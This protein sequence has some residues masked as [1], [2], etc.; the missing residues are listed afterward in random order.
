MT[1]PQ[2]NHD[3]TPSY[4][5]LQPSHHPYYHHLPTTIPIISSPPR[6]SS[7]SSSHHHH[8]HLH[9]HQHCFPTIIIII[10]TPLTWTDWTYVWR[11]AWQSI[12]SRS[13]QSPRVCWRSSWGLE[14]HL[15]HMF[16]LDSVDSDVEVLW[17]VVVWK[18]WGFV[19]GDVEILWVVVVW[20]CWGSMGDGGCRVVCFV[21]NMCSDDDCGDVV[22][23]ENSCFGH[24]GDVGVLSFL[25]RL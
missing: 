18:C 21:S 2:Q 5:Q 20:W 16:C 4:S 3:E 24:C 19:E 11:Q 6:P 15:L 22:R 7:A 10:F 14:E 25:W 23:Y 17:V 12:S 13:V 9:H 1:P 8:H